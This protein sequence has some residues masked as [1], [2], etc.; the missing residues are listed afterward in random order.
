MSHEINLR[1]MQE[2][3]LIEKMRKLFPAVN[4]IHGTKGRVLAVM[5]IGFIVV[6]HSGKV[7]WLNNVWETPED[8]HAWINILKEDI[9]HITSVDHKSTEINP[10]LDDRRPML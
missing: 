6:K 7:K 10:P 8:F 4:W 3:E 5:T 9:G 2:R 1:T